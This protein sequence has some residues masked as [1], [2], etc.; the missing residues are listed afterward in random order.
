MAARKKK[1]GG[2]RKGAG[3]P[4]KGDASRTEPIPVKLSPDEMDALRTDAER[5][6]ITLADLVRGALGF[7]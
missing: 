5:K 4:P 6:G 7:E 1:H 3:R 2:A